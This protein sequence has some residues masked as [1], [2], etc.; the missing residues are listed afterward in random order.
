MLSVRII[1]YIVEAVSL[2]FSGIYVTLNDT[3]F[4]KEIKNGIQ[5]GL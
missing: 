5:K 4:F 1:P 3:K 2:T